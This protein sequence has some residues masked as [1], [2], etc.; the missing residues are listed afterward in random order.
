[1]KKIDKGRLTPLVLS[2]TVRT[3]PEEELFLQEPL[4]N[5]HNVLQV[6]QI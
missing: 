2:E 6:S 4:N 3:I 1:M 5:M